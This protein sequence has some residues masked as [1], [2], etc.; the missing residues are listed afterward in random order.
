MKQASL[1]LNVILTLAVAFL[2]Y[3]HFTSTKSTPAVALTSSASNIA[4]VNSDSLQSNYDFYKDLEDLFENKRKEIQGRVDYRETAFEKE[5]QDYQQKAP[6]MSPQ[7]RAVMEEKLFTKSERLKRQRQEAAESFD[8][9]RVL[10]NDSLFVRIENFIEKYNED[11]GYTYILGHQRG[12]GI[13]YANDSLD[14]TDEVVKLM[15]EEYA[16]EKE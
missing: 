16:A 15:N 7:E 5:V 8:T 13:L 2:M 11:K 1:I 14:I 3:H 9:D 10:Y 12:G 4:Y 6:G